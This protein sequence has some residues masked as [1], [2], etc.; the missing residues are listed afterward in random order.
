MLK[1]T[2]SDVLVSFGE[3]FAEGF[4]RVDHCE[5]RSFP[6]QL[7]SAHMQIPYGFRHEKIIV[8]NFSIEILRRNV[9]N[10]VSSVEI[11]MHS[12]ALGNG[13]LPAGVVCVRVEGV[14]YIG[15]RFIKS[16]YCPEVLFL[17]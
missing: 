2:I 14:D 13:S 7:P 4:V 11:Q 5:A 15:P 16:F 3:K 17:P 10:S 8:L 9:K 12:V 6:A 1:T